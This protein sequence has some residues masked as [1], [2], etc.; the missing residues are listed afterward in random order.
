MIGE[1]NA[2]KKQTPGVNRERSLLCLHR[3]L[4]SPRR[5]HV[6]QR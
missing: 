1:G 6:E 2:W 5:N 4:A 3:G